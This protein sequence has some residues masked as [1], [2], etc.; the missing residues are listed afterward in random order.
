MKHILLLSALL[1][2]QVT[3]AQSKQN[4]L[5]IGAKAI[6]LPVFTNSRI[7]GELGL[8]YYITD[9]FSIG[10]NYMYTNN[11][12]TNGFG[13]DTDRTLIHYLGINIPLQ[14]DVV[15]KEK[16]QLGMGIAPGLNF[17][18]LRDRNQMSEEEYY[19]EETGVTTVISTPVRFN[20]DAYF[21]LTPYID[22]SVKAVDI[23]IKSDVALYITG[24]AGY[25]FAFGNGDFTKP[26]DFR[27]YVV[28][29]GFTIKGALD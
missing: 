29:L 9:G 8:R 26:S 15:N 22:L 27:N 4:D 24:N 18:T 23:D 2:V 14:Y 1:F 13:Y 17:I 3:F 12:F 5:A 19:D 28:S 16:F 10:N 20:R 21:S 11:K 7:G 6:L 25:Q